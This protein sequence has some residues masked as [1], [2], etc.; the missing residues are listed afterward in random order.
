MAK[1]ASTLPT[2][3]NSGLATTRRALF[4]ISDAFSLNT[5]SNA[6]GRKASK[7]YIFVN[8]SKQLSCS[9][10][11]MKIITYKTS[12]LNGQKFGTSGLRKKVGVFKSKNYLENILQ[13]IIVSLNLANKTIVLGGDG[14]YFNKEAILIAIKMLVACGVR[15][16]YVGQN[17]IFST[18]AISHFIRKNQP[19]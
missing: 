11:V 12:P 14:R 19:I 13:A 3:I 10:Q 2:P 17:G 15:K 16:I 4:L 18:P 9:G 6:G 1:K 5:Q 7:I 8:S